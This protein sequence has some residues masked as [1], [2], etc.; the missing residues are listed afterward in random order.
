MS[1]NQ[2]ARPIVI[3]TSTLSSILRIPPDAFLY[4]MVRNIVG[5]LVEVGRGKIPLADFGRLLST[6]ARSL[7]GPTAPAYGL[8]LVQISFAGARAK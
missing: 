7:A 3:K 1:L 8:Y 5:A 6:K 4:H 2:L